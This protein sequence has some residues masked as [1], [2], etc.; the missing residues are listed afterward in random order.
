MPN[1][2]TNVI[3][4]NGDRKQIRELLEQIQ[5]DELGLGTIDFEKIIPMP[6]N[7]YRGNLGQEETKLYG[8]NNWYDWRIANW[9]TKWSAYGYE[10][11]CDYSNAEELRFLTAWAAPH[12]VIQRLSEMFPEIKII[13]EWADEDIGMNCGRY[14][15]YDGERYEEYYAENEKERLEFAARVMDVDLEINYGLYLNASE[16]GYVN[17]DSAD[18]YERIELFGQTAL[19]T[20]DRI[21][22]SD[23]PKGTYCYDL[24]QSDDGER[25]CSIEKRVAVN[26][27]GSVVTK[28]PL[29][30]GEKGFIPLTEDTEPNFMGEIVTFADFIEQTQELGMEMK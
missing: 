4:L 2:V 23:I 27:G 13:H 9:G 25:F 3:K 7:I 8:K 15:Y 19:F 17:I 21:T 12:P 22:D 18:E 29:D 26:C 5:S 28:E 24:R 16:T 1:H 30:L 14:A 20:N 10:K 11:D 6:E